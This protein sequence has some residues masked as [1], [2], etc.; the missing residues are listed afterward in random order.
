MRPIPG[1]VAWAQGQL[2]TPHGPLTVSWQVSGATTTVSV[3]GPDGTR[4]TVALPGASERVTVREGRTVL[5]DGQRGK[6]SSVDTA[7]GRVTVALTG[8]NARTFTVVR[9]D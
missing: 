6:T 5:W 7:D 8:G 1:D 2:P 9:A 3:Q 4:G